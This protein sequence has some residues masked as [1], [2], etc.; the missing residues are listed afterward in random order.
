MEY[1]N[2]T[3]REAEQELIKCGNQFELLDEYPPLPEVAEKFDFN[4][5]INS[6][7]SN[8]KPSNKLDIRNKLKYNI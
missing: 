1:C 3:F 4:K 2:K 5:F 6:K 8:S 7:P